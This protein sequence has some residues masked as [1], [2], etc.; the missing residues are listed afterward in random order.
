MADAALFTALALCGLRLGTSAG[1]GRGTEHG[2]TGRGGEREKV[3]QRRSTGD[4]RDQDRI[5]RMNGII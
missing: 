2:K 4:R 1:G 5:N 3:R